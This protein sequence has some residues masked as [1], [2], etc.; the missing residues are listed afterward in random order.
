MNQTYSLLICLGFWR[1]FLLLIADETLEKIKLNK[2]SYKGLIKSQTLSY[3]LGEEERNSAL[4][5]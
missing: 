3:F 2:N 5:F 1:R 4:N